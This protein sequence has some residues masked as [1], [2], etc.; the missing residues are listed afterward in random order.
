MRLQQ[1]KDRVDRA[2]CFVEQIERGD[3][4]LGEALRRNQ[5]LCRDFKSLTMKANQILA[6]QE[7]PSQRKQAQKVAAEK[8]LKAVVRQKRLN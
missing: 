2:V 4:T 3:W 8:K 7:R 1:S 5:K 6:K